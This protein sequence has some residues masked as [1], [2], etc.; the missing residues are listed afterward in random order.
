MKKYTD[1]YLDPISKNDVEVIDLVF[2]CALV[3]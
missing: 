2:T 3:S 1:F